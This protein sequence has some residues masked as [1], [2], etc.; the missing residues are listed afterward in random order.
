M[1]RAA[2]SHPVIVIGI[3]GLRWSDISKSVTPSIWR[4][5][6]SGSVASL[7]TTTVHATTCPA[8][9]WLTVNSGDRS[10]EPPGTKLRCPPVPVLASA[11]RAIQM[12]QIPSM[13]AI[14]SYN[15]GTG[16]E[17]HWGTLRAAA[18]PGGCSTAIGAGAGLALA[19]RAGD[20]AR[21]SAKPLAA[22]ESDAR[23]EFA[24]CPFTMVDLG[25]LPVSSARTVRL[26]AADRQVAAIVAAAPAGTVIA[27][28]GMGDDDSPQLRALIVAGPATTPGCLPRT[29]PGSPASSRSPTSPRASL[30][31]AG[32]PCPRA[33]RARRLRTCAGDHCPPPLPR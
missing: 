4:L 24:R 28:A 30:V 8:D 19:N 2:P 17:P 22:S 6:E 10:A 13:P 31:G 26:R 5:A 23:A 14:I 20:V 21:Y 7:V 16:Y 29:R 12:A 11:G 32:S 18:G 15:N 25:S 1:A 9:A 3:A 27:L 33:W